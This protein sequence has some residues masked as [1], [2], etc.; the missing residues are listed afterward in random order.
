M[1]VCLVFTS[2]VAG[3]R[4]VQ[5]NYELVFGSHVVSPGHRLDTGSDL[6]S[7]SKPVEG[8]MKRLKFN[9]P[10]YGR[11]NIHLRCQCLQKMQNAVHLFASQSLLRRLSFLMGQCQCCGLLGQQGIQGMV[12]SLDF[13]PVQKSRIRYWFQ[14]FNLFEGVKLEVDFR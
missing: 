6:G 2:K 12:L 10:K 3:T 11:C 7:A 4:K 1:N 14:L 9:R 13:P 5:R 8:T